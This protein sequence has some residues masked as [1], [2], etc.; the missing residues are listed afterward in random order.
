MTGVHDKLLVKGVRCMG[1]RSSVLSAP[2]NGK[3]VCTE[4]KPEADSGFMY[5]YMFSQT[6]GLFFTL[7]RILPGGGSFFL[8]VSQAHL[9]NSLTLWLLGHY[10]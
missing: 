3:G 1:C 8:E 7:S 10:R 4:S 6:L 5:S 2:K 9:G